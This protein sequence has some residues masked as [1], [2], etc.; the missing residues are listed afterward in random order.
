VHGLIL[1]ARFLIFFR[2]GLALIVDALDGI[3][4]IGVEVL[5]IQAVFQ[6]ERGFML[7]K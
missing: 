3:D 6:F 4:V 5:A 1:G 7:G 2:L